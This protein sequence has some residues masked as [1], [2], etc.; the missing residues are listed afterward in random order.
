MILLGVHIDSAPIAEAHAVA[1]A[2]ALL[3]LFLGIEEGVDEVSHGG[4]MA[5]LRDDGHVEFLRE[6]HYLEVVALSRA[7]ERRGKARVLL[8]VEQVIDGV[9]DEVVGK[10]VHFSVSFQI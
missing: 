3:V 2:D 1:E 10:A 9:A 8:E 7:V 6:E 4:V 5:G